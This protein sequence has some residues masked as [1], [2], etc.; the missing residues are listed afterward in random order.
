VVPPS[1]SITYTIYATGG[2]DA[3]TR[4]YANPDVWRWLYSQSQ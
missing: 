2:H 4:T 3:W 1:G